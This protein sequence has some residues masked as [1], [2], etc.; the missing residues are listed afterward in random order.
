M[1]LK[2]PSKFFSR[3]RKARWLAFFLVAMLLLS[4]ACGQRL[5]DADLLSDAAPSANDNAALGRYIE[6]DSLLPVNVLQVLALEPQS[7]GLL[8]L[9]GYYQSTSGESKVGAWT[10]AEGDV[11]W[12]EAS[13]G[14]LG[15]IQNLHINSLTVTPDGTPYFSYFVIPDEQKP[16]DDGVDGI[17]AAA[18][19]V[20][21]VPIHHTIA[22]VKNGAIVDMGY[23][24]Q[25]M[26]EDMPPTS[27]RMLENGDILAQYYASFIVHDGKSGEILHRFE[28][29]DWMQG[30]G[31]YVVRGDVLAYCNKNIIVSL[32]MADGKTQAE[33]AIQGA[34]D[35]DMSSLHYTMPPPTVLALAPH[36][37]G[38]IYYVNDSGIYRSAADGQVTEKIVDGA[39]NSLGSPSVRVVRMQVESTGNFIVATQTQ[40]VDAAT[41]ITRY[42]YDADT[43]TIPSNVVRVYSL[44]DNATVRQTMSEFQRQNPDVMVQYEVGM[45]QSEG[46]T[47]NDAIKALNTQILSGKGPDALLLD[48]LPMDSLVKN[49]L[50]ANLDG[51][52]DAEA[53]NALQVNIIRPFETEGGR[54]AVPA[55]YAFPV[56]LAPTDSADISQTPGALANFVLGQEKHEIGI[57][58]GEF[59]S[60]LVS[61]YA[62]RWLDEDNQLRAD[63]FAQDMED[64]QPL[65]AEYEQPE[66]AGVNR[67]FLFGCILTKNGMSTVY[68]GQ[69]TRVDDFSGAYTLEK[70]GAGIELT[71]FRN[72]HKSF[73]PSALFGVLADSRQQK[74][75]A[76]FVE[77]ALSESVQRHALGDGLPV[78]R[79]AMFAS[80]VYPYE[81][82]HKNAANV[83]ERPMGAMMLADK[84]EQPMLFEYFWPDEA[85]WDKIN[86]LIDELGQPTLLDGALADILVEKADLYLFGGHSIDE[87]VGDLKKKLVLY[88]SE[89]RR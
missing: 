76:D 48:S 84:N 85:Y 30:E 17:A 11:Q 63:V 83:D 59:S 64:L 79:A 86:A 45:E 34:A 52:L 43:P 33:F 70:K 14:W 6:E 81:E 46:Y 5:N 27:F 15:A 28:S 10:L 41:K 77:Y 40:Q 82:L 37:P 73:V 4:A 1:K 9:V 20:S 24:L 3:W 56:L 8:L 67:D 35:M 62:D 39:L 32:R 74:L 54:F 29:G 88:R 57:G 47:K 23:S 72:D 78:N 58:R 16:P 7:D 38:S 65:A 53:I 26:E 2:T 49:E 51:L 31:M 21:A 22:T 13:L 25:D 12:Q 55:R 50:L 69:M 68:T 71:A 66:Y 87:V 18:T 19:A 80:Q 42:R 89:K 44:Y 61:L 36:D 75:A 60:R